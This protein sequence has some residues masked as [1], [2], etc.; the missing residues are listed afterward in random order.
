MTYPLPK[1]LLRLP[2]SRDKRVRSGIAAI[3]LLLRKNMLQEAA[4]QLQQL[5]Q[6]E[7]S[8]V[9]IALLQ[10]ELLTMARDHDRACQLLK[11]IL[12]RHPGLVP[13]NILSARA[14]TGAQ[15]H[16]DALD[17]LRLA[18]E[19][20]PA[21]DKTLRQMVET[22][23]VLKHHDE[24]ATA[25][26]R[27]MRKS[28]SPADM[29]QLALLQDK[30]GDP[31][32]ALAAYDKVKL[33]LPA[34][35]DIYVLRAGALLAH[36]RNEDARASIDHAIAANPDNASLRLFI[37]KNFLSEFGADQQISEISQIL[38]SET[39]ARL[40]AEDRAR[41][42]FAL[43]LSH[44]KAG[45]H[46]QAFAAVKAANELTAPENMALEQQVEKVASGIADHFTKARLAQL[47]PAGHS[48][49]QPVFV[50]GLPRSGTTLVEQIIAAH[51]QASSL[52]ELELIPS[53]K[54]SLVSLQSRDIQRCAECWL[55]AVPEADAG[56]QRIVDK[57][58]S[59]LLHTG[60]A[61]L[62]FPKARFLFVRRH[63]MD[64]YW[65]AY[66]EMFGT[67]AVTFSYD[68]Q[69]LIRRISFYDHLMKLWK[70][71]FP[72][73]IMEVRYEQLVA[74]L[75]PHAREIIAHTGLE[76]NETC[77]KFHKS[78]SVVRTA[79]MAQVR[80]PVY[81]SSVGKWQ[82]YAHQLATVAEAMS[83]LIADYENES[84][85]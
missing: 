70:E 43:G 16:L 65:S 45:Q 8:N 68:P 30:A 51:P 25:F 19:L 73:R 35:A 84:T 79:S 7:P 63:P 41:L 10:A 53:L 39:S 28:T 26:A 80:Q 74:D 76:W 11:Q 13:A 5:Q 31:D 60:L 32:A 42:G 12:A 64:V 50:T 44:E 67:G 4:V 72:D 21:D 15:R 22:L 34:M 52:G 9:E 24:A 3:A 36:G 83:G 71:R 81:S 75:E 38:A 2:P 48:S 78:A 69:A 6:V 62:M 1:A 20:V 40:T 77:L 82:A 49:R 66:R 55:A 85:A 57:S 37:A 17:A 18:N 29:V 23:T 14:H 58:I 61:M 27:A 54:Q 33:P 56:K 47:A 46:R 59:T